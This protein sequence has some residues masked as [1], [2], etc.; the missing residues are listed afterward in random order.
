MVPEA[1]S[2][3]HHLG[4]PKLL[5]SMDRFE[6]RN[7][8]SILW[9]H[10]LSSPL[11][12]DTP[13]LPV[14]FYFLMLHSLVSL[15]FFCGLKLEFFSFSFFYFIQYFPKLISASFS[16]FLCVFVSWSLAAF[17]SSLHLP[18]YPIS[19]SPRLQPPT[20]WLPVP[21]VLGCQQWITT[22]L[23]SPPVLLVQ[24]VVLD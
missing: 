7:L 10:R 1:P 21:E 14:L 23:R 8:F 5:R 13:E 19:L 4:L 22:H 20:P 16:H 3:S 15:L 2:N 12:P 11:Q 9:L 24:L 6:E 17:L 18:L